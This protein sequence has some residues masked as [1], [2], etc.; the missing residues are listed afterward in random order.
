MKDDIEQPVEFTKAGLMNVRITS[1]CNGNTI[2]YD[3]TLQSMSLNTFIEKNTL[4]GFK[5]KITYIKD[6]FTI[7]DFYSKQIFT[8]MRYDELIMSGLYM[9]PC[10]KDQYSLN[11]SSVWMYDTT[12]FDCIGYPTKDDFMNVN[13]YQKCGNNITLSEIEIIE[14][15]ICGNIS[16]NGIDYS[17][18]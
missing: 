3:S 14:L 12:A 7:T 1:S 9:P 8:K 17:I 13:F 18:V 4:D 5:T 6:I 10:D 15:L 11:I 16:V 2:Q